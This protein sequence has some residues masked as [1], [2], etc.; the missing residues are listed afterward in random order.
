MKWKPPKPRSR[1]L[2]PRA[3]SNR[4]ARAKVWQK[5][6]QREHHKCAGCGARDHMLV[7]AHVMG[8]PGSGAALGEWANSSELTTALCCS[9]PKD[10]HVGCHEKFDSHQDLDVAAKVLGE[11]IC[12]LTVRGAVLPDLRMSLSPAGRVEYWR[13]C[14][15]SQVRWLEENGVEP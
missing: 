2:G 8:R 14:I 12:R 13:S 11:A 1:A 7:W 3:Q 5:V 9:D 6:L 4:Q 15:R 10:G